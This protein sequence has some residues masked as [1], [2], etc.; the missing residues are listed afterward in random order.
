MPE[1]ELI[2]LKKILFF[3]DPLLPIF[4]HPANELQFFEKQISEEAFESF[5]GSI[6]D[7]LPLLGYTSCK[8]R[9]FSVQFAAVEHFANS[10]FLTIRII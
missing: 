6:Q 9:P 8:F 3:Y 5:I 4:F 1:L 10:L 2:W 7:K